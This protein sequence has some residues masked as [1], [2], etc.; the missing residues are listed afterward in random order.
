M[1][2]RAITSLKDCVEH[3]NSNEKGPLRTHIFIVESPT[4]HR[5]HANKV[6]YSIVLPGNAYPK[7]QSVRVSSP[8]HKEFIDPHSVLSILQSS[9]Y[10]RGASQDQTLFTPTLTQLG[11]SGLP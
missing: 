2:P 8:S 4:R 9:I 6:M 11:F 3:D 7:F 10:R 5:G 1:L